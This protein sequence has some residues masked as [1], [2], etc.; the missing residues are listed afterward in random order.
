MRETAGGRASVAPPPL[1]TGGARPDLHAALAGAGKSGYTG[2]MKWYEIAVYTTDAGIEP[3]CG[4]LTGAGLEGFSIEESREAAAAFLR[5]SA[6]YWDFADMARIGT[7]TPCVKAYLAVLPENAAKLDAVRAAVAGLRQADLGVD[8]GPLAVRV[9][10]R[11]DEDWA[12]NWKRYYKPIEI[13]ERLLVLPSWEP[14][15]ETRRTVLR[16]DPGLAFGTGAHHTTRMCLELLERTVRPGDAL[17]DLGCGSGILSIAGRLLG[18]ARAV[19]VDIDPVA[20]R[21]AHENAALNGADD[22]GYTIEIGDVLT[23][24]A[25]RCR[26]AGAYDVVVANI[27]ADVI[28]RLAP[29]AFSCCR[30]GAPFIASG[31]IDEREAEV[32]DAVRAAG[33]VLEDARRAGGWVA[34]RARRRI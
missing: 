28:I 7:D 8:L 34:L 25:L 6:L 22:A 18:A 16:L 4:A 33:F 12:N 23:D 11:D 21:I 30:P 26:I 27:V 10:V 20:E 1:Q 14:C 32:A 15:P 13:G 29:F 17:L 5:E 9:T 31:I 2:T 19:A 24:A 3:V